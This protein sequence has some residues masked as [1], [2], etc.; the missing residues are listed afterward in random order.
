[1][2]S[3]ADAGDAAAGYLSGV[4]GLAVFVGEVEETVSLGGLFQPVDECFHLGADDILCTS[5]TDADDY[6]GHIGDSEMV[7]GAFP[8]AELNGAILAE[9]V[10]AGSDRV[11]VEC[12]IIGVAAKHF[13]DIGTEVLS[14]NL[15]CIRQS[16]SKLGFALIGTRSQGRSPRWRRGLWI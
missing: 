6:E 5:E 10:D 1:M 3:E 7:F 14:A 4:E 11:P 13:G 2:E 16:S 15:G 9:V 8:Q 12:G